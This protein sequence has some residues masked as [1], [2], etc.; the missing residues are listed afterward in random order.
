MTPCFTKSYVAPEVLNKQG[1]FCNFRVQ[2]NIYG[3]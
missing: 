1:S 3:F 2:M